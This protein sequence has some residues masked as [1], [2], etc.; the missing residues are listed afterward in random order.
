MGG[1]AVGVP[2]TVPI[3]YFASVSTTWCSQS[4]VK[5]PSVFS[6]R[7]HANSAMRATWMPIAFI[8]AA[9]FSISSTGQSSG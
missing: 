5:T 8:F 2:K 4:N 6:M 3:P 1:V 9:S 7:L